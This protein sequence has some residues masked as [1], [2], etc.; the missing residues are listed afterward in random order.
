MMPVFDPLS[1]IWPYNLLFIFMQD[2]GKACF[3]QRLN[4]YSREIK[5]E[6]LEEGSGAAQSAVS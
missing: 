5:S 2:P 4:Q 3:C 6:T 1:V